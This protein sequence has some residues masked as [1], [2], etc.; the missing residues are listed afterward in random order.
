MKGLSL[1]IAAAL[2]RIQAV[3]IVEFEGGQVARTWHTED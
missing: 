3:E 1:L 2:M